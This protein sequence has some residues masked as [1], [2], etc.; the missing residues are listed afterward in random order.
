LTEESS[1][2]YG[3]ALAEFHSQTDDFP[4]D[5]A[6]FHFDASSMVDEPLARIKPLFSEHSDDYDHLLEISARLKQAA[7]GLPR[8]APEYGICH[9]DVNATNFHLDT[10]GWSLIDFEYFGYG[11]RIFDIATFFNNTYIEGGI[12]DDTKKV[13]DA[14]LAGYQEIRPLSKSEL[15]TLPSFV[16]MRQIWLLG[17]SARYIPKST[18]T[19]PQHEQWMFQ[20]VMPFIRSWKT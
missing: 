11:W 15:E 1:R 3:R 4:P 7:E 14:F 16:L 10:S 18:V 8:T 2:R 5:R 9:G 20:H 17:T 19:M 6:G 12:N 13:L